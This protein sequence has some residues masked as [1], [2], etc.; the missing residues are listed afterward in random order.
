MKQGKIILIPFPFAELTNIKLRPAVLIST[1][2]DKYQD[3]ILCAVS[4]VIPDNL[5][6]FEIILKPTSLN[7]LKIQSIIKVDRIFTL[8]KEDM[9]A[10]LGELSQE[11]SQAF[12]SKLKKLIE[13]T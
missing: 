6:G 1:T 4:S 2:Q 8:K 7:L 9:I 13:Q 10:E 11:E 12:K 5:S 3:L